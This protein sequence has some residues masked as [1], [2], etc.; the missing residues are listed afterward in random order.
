MLYCA[1]AEHDMEFC[2]NLNE[3]FSCKFKV[4]LVDLLKLKICNLHVRAYKHTRG[5]SSRSGYDYSTIKSKLL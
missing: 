4:I 1:C 3:T 5:I 2:W